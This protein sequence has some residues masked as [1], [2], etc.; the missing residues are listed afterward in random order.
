M[1]KVGQAVFEI[2]EMYMNYFE[3]EVIARVV[4]VPLPFVLG[5]IDSIDQNSFDQLQQL[6]E[7]EQYE[8][9]SGH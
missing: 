9:Q 2:E 3:P 7:Q 5:V 4:G 1:S 6:E 8:E